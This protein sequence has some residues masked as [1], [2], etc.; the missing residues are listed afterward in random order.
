[1]E[2]MR[3]LLLALAA[4]LVLGGAAFLLLSSASG[5]G[6]GYEGDRTALRAGDDGPGPGGIPPAASGESEGKGTPP[7]GT[8]ARG[9]PG[10]R[11]LPGRPGGEGG[12]EAPRPPK[13]PRED[14]PPGEIL[15]GDLPEE[16]AEKVEETRR[17]LQETDLGKVQWRGRTLK[18]VAEEIASKSGV[19]VVLEGDDLADEPVQMGGEAVSARAALDHIA[20]SRTLR[21]EVQ[22]GKVVIK[23]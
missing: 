19:A 7:A 16:E 9:N 8:S 18:S 3:N 11:T 17:T 14:A 21:F 5:P 10:E 15:K 13:P 22:P 23:R 6:P 1:M 2:E 20:G 12:G 4:L